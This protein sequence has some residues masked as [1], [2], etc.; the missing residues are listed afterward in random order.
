MR[1]LLA[2]AQQALSMIGLLHEGLP[3]LLPLTAAFLP[4]KSRFARLLTNSHVSTEAAM[5]LRRR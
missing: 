4:G 3:E 5:R 1:R 2:R